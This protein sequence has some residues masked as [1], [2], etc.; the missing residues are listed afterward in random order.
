LS[1][2]A[3]FD[4]IH[5]YSISSWIA[6]GQPWIISGIVMEIIIIVNFRAECYFSCASWYSD[7]CCCTKTSL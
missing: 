1:S 7:T 4:Y 6:Y 5:I 3:S 2:S